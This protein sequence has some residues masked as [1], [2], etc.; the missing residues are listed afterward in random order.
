MI[1]DQYM[2]L[3][4]KSK[5]YFEIGKIWFVVSLQSDVYEIEIVS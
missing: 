5:D 1:N 4:K 2:G 3:I